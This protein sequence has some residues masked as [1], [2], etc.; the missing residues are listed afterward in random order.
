MI[1]RPAILND[2]SIILDI[3]AT[4]RN[5]MRNTGNADQWKNIYPPKDLLEKDI[6][7]GNLYVVCEDS[8][9]HAVFAFIPGVD[10][11]YNEIDGAWLNDKP[12]AAIH[13]V[14]SA[15]KKKGMLH[16][17]VNYALQHSD[18]IKIDTHH[19]NKVMQHQL[20]KE[21]FVRCGIIKLENGEPRI[22]YQKL[23]ISQ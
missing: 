16:E 7:N 12:Y 23:K 19:D 3:Y 17:C 18:N 10:P 4:A 2:L 14:A 1:V 11:T 22:A 13:R 20:E 6:E 5:F 21:G 8:E 15:G 9:I